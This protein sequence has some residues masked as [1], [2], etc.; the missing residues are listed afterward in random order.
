MPQGSLLPGIPSPRP[1]SNSPDLIDGGDTARAELESK[2]GQG[3]ALNLKGLWSPEERRAG[4]GAESAA[5]SILGLW[6][7]A[8]HS[9]HHVLPKRRGLSTREELQL[10]RVPMS[11]SQR[12]IQLPTI[13]GSWGTYTHNADEETEDH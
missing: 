6:P 1:S 10:A 5:I 9:R 11:Q 12:I 7:P 3:Y 4:Q 13:Q 8:G 2:M